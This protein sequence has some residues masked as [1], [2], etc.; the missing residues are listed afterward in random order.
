MQS[1]DERKDFLS[2]AKKPEVRIEWGLQADPKV[3]TYV[4]ENEDQKAFFIKGV[5][6]GCGWLECKIINTEEDK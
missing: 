3:K 5:E 6:E 1:K 2:Q 4:F